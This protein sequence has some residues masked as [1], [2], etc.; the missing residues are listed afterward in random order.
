MSV[1]EPPNYGTPPPPPPGGDSPYGGQPPA[2]EQRSMSV[3]SLISMI[4]GIVGLCCSGIFVVSI[5]ATVLGFL[6]RKEVAE[7]GGMKTGGGMALAG[8]ILGVVGVV[9]GIVNWVLVA[10]G[11]VD[12]TWNTNV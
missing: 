2:G 8:I 3:M 10:T 1:N 11:V 12:M 7:S 6:G 9:L 4:V 5:A